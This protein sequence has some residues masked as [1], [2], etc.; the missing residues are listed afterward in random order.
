[1]LILREYLEELLFYYRFYYDL[2]IKVTNQELIAVEKNSLLL[3]SRGGSIA[4][5][6]GQHWVALGSGG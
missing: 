1:M 3:I 2:G 4:H 5:H 6:G